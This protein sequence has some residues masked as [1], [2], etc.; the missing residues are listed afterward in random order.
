[1]RHDVHALCG[2]TKNHPAWYLHPKPAG[3][4][5]PSR[6]GVYEC[7]YVAHLKRWRHG[8]SVHTLFL[9]TFSDAKRIVWGRPPIHQPRP[10]KQDAHATSKQGGHQHEGPGTRPLPAMPSRRSR[11]GG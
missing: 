1:M 10:D 2:V 11:S 6:N 3:T 9:G 5:E 7:V 8:L 4:F